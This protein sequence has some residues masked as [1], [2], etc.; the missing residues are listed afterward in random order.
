MTLAELKNDY[1]ICLDNHLT[2]AWGSD[3]A[4]PFGKIKK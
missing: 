2:A 4:E 3:C 1:D